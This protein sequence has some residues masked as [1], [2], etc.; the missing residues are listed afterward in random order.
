MAKSYLTKR[1]PI[2]GP[3]ELMETSGA[4][5]GLMST[6]AGQAA[7]VRL[8]TKAGDP[9]S[10][11]RS[12]STCQSFVTW[13]DPVH[14]NV[15]SKQKPF[16]T[17]PF[18]F[19]REVGRMSRTALLLGGTGLV[20]GHCLNQLIADSRYS[21][22]TAL[23]RRLSG[24]DDSE[25]RLDARVVDFD[26]L[27]EE[28]DFTATDVYCCLGTPMNSSKETFRR[29]DHDYPVEVAQLARDAGAQRLAIV[30]AVG[31]NPGSRVSLLRV[32]GETERDIAA[33]GYE[34]VE[35]FQPATLLGDRTKPR[36][37][38]GVANAI[39]PVAARAMLG[40]LRRFRPVRAEDVATA[41]IAACSATSRGPHPHLSGDHGV[42]D[43]GPLGAL[44]S[45]PEQDGDE[46][47]ARRTAGASVWSV[48]GVAQPGQRRGP[49][50]CRPS[51]GTRLIA[52]SCHDHRIALD[53]VG[54]G[55]CHV[56][57]G[58]GGGLGVGAVTDPAGPVPGTVGSHELY[59]HQPVGGVDQAARGVFSQWVTDALTIGVTHL[60]RDQPPRTH[61]ALLQCRHRRLRP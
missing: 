45:F 11:T 57:T 23:V 43:D 31:A 19:L 28:W 34:C 12:N 39:G 27:A 47:L 59:R 41:M 51:S 26:Q 29:V 18:E 25:G 38:Q 44:D 17:K 2:P 53:T 54:P 56:T 10:A 21:R 35:I 40:P 30:S 58:S 20:G 61:Q 14:G 3:A 37:G 4:A 22:V 7:V 5:G 52:G 60:V 24:V 42:G 16:E 9:L 48:P 1:Q 55:I 15:R 32:K 33:L 13:I 8:I 50:S 6:E 36:S 46:A 49:W